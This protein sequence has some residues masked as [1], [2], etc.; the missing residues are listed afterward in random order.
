MR[1]FIHY[2]LE[3]ILKDNRECDIEGMQASGS[4][5]WRVIEQ[6]LGSYVCATHYTQTAKTE[7]QI[8]YLIQ[9]SIARIEDNSNNNNNTDRR[10]KYAHT[11]FNLT[12]LLHRKLGAGFFCSHEITSAFGFFSSDFPCVLLFYAIICFFLYLQILI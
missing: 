7:T 8:V 4:C 1:T 11:H 10:K 2:A 6:Q 3:I 5:T 12:S 9:V